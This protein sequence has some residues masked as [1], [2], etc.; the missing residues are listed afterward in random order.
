MSEQVAGEREKLTLAQASEHLIEESRMVLPGMQALFGFQLIVVFNS[1]FSDKLGPLQQQLHLLAISL[2]VIAIALIMTPAAYH[3]MT[4]PRAVSGHF[5][6]A[7]SH[8]LLLSMAPLALA[9]CID[10]YVVAWLV[11]G[12]SAAIVLAASLLAVFAY[13]WFVLPRVKRARRLFG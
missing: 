8:M 4:S 11:I 1:T 7:S 2:V 12:S 13:M 3:R 6:N 9:I 10:L 5:I